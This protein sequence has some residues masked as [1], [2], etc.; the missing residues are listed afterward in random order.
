MVSKYER[1]KILSSLVETMQAMAKVEWFRTYS[2]D[3]LKARLQ[4]DV[5]VRVDNLSMRGGKYYKQSKGLWVDSP[6]GSKVGNFELMQE[7]VGSQW[8]WLNR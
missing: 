8:S 6:R 4:M 5:S 7:C 3:T 1:N 2:V